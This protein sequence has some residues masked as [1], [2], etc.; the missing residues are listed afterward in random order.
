MLDQKG[1]YLIGYR[2]SESTFN[3]AGGKN[4]HHLEVRVKRA[5]LIVR[6]RSGF[7]GVNTERAKPFIARPTAVARRAH[8]AL[9]NGR[10]R[11]ALDVSVS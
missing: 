7:Y 3:A 9:C 6:T 5:D 11:F 2:P 4:F 1:Y 8:F 10:A